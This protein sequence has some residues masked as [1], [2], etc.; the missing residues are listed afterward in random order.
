MTHE[1]NLVLNAFALV[2]FFKAGKIHYLCTNFLGDAATRLIDSYKSFKA[3]PRTIYF[4]VL[5]F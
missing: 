4:F 2:F 1:L 3:K 5:L